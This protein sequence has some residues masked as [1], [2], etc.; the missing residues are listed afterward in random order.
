M[1]KKTILL[2]LSIILLSFSF[3]YT[4]KQPQVPS[5]IKEQLEVYKVN[6]QDL[7]KEKWDDF[8]IKLEKSH[9]DDINNLL[10]QNGQTMMHQAAKNGSYKSIQKLLELGYD[11]NQK[12][13]FGYTPIFY[14][15]SNSSYL[16]FINYLIANGAKLDLYK[17]EN[18]KDDALS[19]ALKINEKQSRK[20][21]KSKIIDFLKQE[22]FSYKKK[23]F[24]YLKENNEEYLMQFVK[25][26]KINEMYFEKFAFGYFEYI[27]AKAEDETIDYMLENKVNLKTYP[28]TQDLLQNALVNPKI[29]IHTIK[30]LIN[31]GLDINTQNAEGYTALMV[32]IK[33]GSIDQVKF[34]LENGASTSIQNNNLENAYS[35]VENSNK[36]NIR[37]KDLIALLDKY[38]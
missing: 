33:R 29:S 26:L 17:N 10:S 3:G 21:N 34:L 16:D 19:F 5:Y 6:E 14:A 22:G 30:K 2:S 28:R 8:L 27:I 13:R 37:K 1:N 12:D 38:N 7:D 4:I 18:K 24:K 36:S 20:Y 31:K 23:H 35:F 11:I 32:A 25:K 9:F 15:I